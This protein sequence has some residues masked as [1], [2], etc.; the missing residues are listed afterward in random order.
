M[1]KKLAIL[2]SFGLLFTLSCSEKEPV[3]SSISN[4]NFTPC[5]QEIL[6]SSELSGKVNIEF[7]E[8]GVQVLYSNFAVT[9]DFTDVAVTHTFENGVLNITQ[10][11]SPSQANCICYTD[12]SY[13]IEGI[14]Q[15]EVN[16]IFINGKQV[17]CYNEN[18]SL[19]GTKWKLAG[20]YDTQTGALT[21]LEP[22]D[23]AECYT[24]M[25]DTDSTLSGKG[26]GNILDGKCEINYKTYDIHISIGTATFVNILFDEKL[27]LDSLNKVYRFSLQEDKLFLYFNKHDYLLFNLLKP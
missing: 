9:C 6:K 18:L 7:T 1:M 27:Y 22:K 23:C 14:A 5:R 19:K 11:A 13:T 26:V 25:F 10:K 21:E 2:I 3:L 4:V 16:V 20:I 15:N 12:V 8:K 17:Y 24:L